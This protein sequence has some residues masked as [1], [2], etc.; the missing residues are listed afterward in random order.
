M[1]QIYHIENNENGSLHIYL[2]FQINF[3][4][5]LAIYVNFLSIE[6]ILFTNLLFRIR[7]AA[8]VSVP[9]HTQ[10]IIQQVALTIL[11]TIFPCSIIQKRLMKRQ[12]T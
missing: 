6:L 12:S 10:N 8:V 2:S 4:H 3:P 5:P 9:H 1:I 7:A 11:G